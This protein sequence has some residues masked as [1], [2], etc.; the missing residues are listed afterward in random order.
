MLV[1]IRG[2]HGKQVSHW[3]RDRLLL[4]DLHMNVTE[5]TGASLSSLPMGHD[6]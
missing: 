3:Q 2:Q 6:V 1:A 5:N 4:K